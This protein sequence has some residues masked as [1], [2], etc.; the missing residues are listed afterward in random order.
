MSHLSAVSLPAHGVGVI[1]LIQIIAAATAER[2]DRPI[3]KHKVTGCVW[4]VEASSSNHVSASQLDVPGQ[5]GQC[6]LFM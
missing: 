5:R 1:R 2:D 3:S 6:C 4:G